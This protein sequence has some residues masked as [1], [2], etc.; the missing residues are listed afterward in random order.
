MK[1]FEITGLDKA[2]M[3]RLEKVAMRYCATLEER[4]G[5][6][7]EGG[8]SVDFPEVSV[9]SLQ[10]MLAEAYKLGRA[11]VRKHFDLT[12]RG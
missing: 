12:Y 11:D 5:I 2:T 1:R 9:Y 3:E 10:F 4:G 6:A 7:G 8:D